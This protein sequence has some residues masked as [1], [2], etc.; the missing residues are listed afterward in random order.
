MNTTVINR[1]IAYEKILKHVECP[2]CSIDYGLGTNFLAQR[3]EDHK[4]WYCP[5]GHSLLFP[6]D[7]TEERAIRE[8]DA[9][10]QLAA[11]QNDRRRAAEARER[12][13]EY[14][15]RAAKGQLTKIRNRLAAGLCPCC[16]KNF[17]ELEA[18]IAEHH[19]KFL[20]PED[21]TTN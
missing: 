15:R 10:R 16:G 18:H 4:R 9:A 7:N 11:H 17:P 12:A 1:T 6:K 5:N 8:R 19:P 3:R 21:L 13:T 2:V 14:R 20:L